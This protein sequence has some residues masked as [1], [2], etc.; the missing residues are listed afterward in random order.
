MNGLEKKK[1]AR[2]KQDSKVGEGRKRRKHRK[3]EV[4]VETPVQ[5][6]ESAEVAS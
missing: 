1:D 2:K 4:T 6:R 5:V 3:D